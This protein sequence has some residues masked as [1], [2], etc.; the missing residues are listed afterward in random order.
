MSP[1][2]R[3][4]RIAELTDEMNRLTARYNRHHAQT[5]RAIKYYDEC[6]DGD[7]RKAKIVADMHRYSDLTRAD[8]A[9]LGIIVDELDELGAFE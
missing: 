9:A 2:S 5:Q 8:E 1:A 4:A 3:E 7:R 6:P